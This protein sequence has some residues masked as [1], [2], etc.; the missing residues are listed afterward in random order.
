MCE[1]GEV[2]AF[3][4]VGDEGVNADDTEDRDATVEFKA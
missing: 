3:A 1:T 2:V 4:D